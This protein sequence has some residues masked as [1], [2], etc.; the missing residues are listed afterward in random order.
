MVTVLPN[1]YHNQESRLSEW[2]SRLNRRPEYD[3]ILY[4]GKKPVCR[5]YHPGNEVSINLTRHNIAR[6]EYWKSFLYPNNVNELDLSY[7]RIDNVEDS[8]F[9]YMIN[10]RF[11][12][13]SHNYLT[14][15][16]AITSVSAL[17]TLNI[18]HNFI[19]HV[20]INR[21]HGLKLL[22]LSGNR[23]NEIG[24]EFSDLRDLEYLDLSSNLI[25]VAAFDAFQYCSSLRHLDL[26]RNLLQVFF[27]NWNPSMT[28]YTNRTRL[29][30]IFPSPTPS[31]P[32]P[33]RHLNLSHNRIKRI[34]MR[35][36]PSLQI[37]DLSFNQ[38]NGDYPSHSFY[39]SLNHSLN[40]SLN[41]SLSRYISHSMIMLDNA[42][43]LSHLNLDHNQCGER[44]AAFY[45]SIAQTARLSDLSLNY[46][47]IPFFHTYYYFSRHRRNT[48]IQYGAETLRLK[49]NEIRRISYAFGI[50]YH[51]SHIDLSHNQISYISRLAFQEM[52]MLETVDLRYN[53][54]QALNGELAA[55]TR[56]IR[57]RRKN[58]F[59]F[60]GNDLSCDC[61]STF[62][63]DIQDVVAD[64]DNITCSVV[65]GSTALLRSL[66]K[67]EFVCQYENECDEDSCSCC[68]DLSA[69]CSCR[70]NCPQ[71][72][73]CIHDVSDTFNSVKCQGNKSQNMPNA[74]HPSLKIL[75]VTGRNITQLRRQHLIN[76]RLLEKISL[77]N[78]SIQ[79]IE[80]F[81][82]VDLKHLRHLDLSF[83]EISNLEPAIFKGLSVLQ[84]L[85]LN[86][87]LLSHVAGGTF[88]ELIALKSLHLENNMLHSLNL[89]LILGHYARPD[90]YLSDNPWECS[91]LVGAMFKN[92]LS[93]TTY[94]IKDID[95][96]FCENIDV[97]LKAGQNVTSLAKVHV[98]DVDYEPCHALALNAF[99]YQLGIELGIGSGLAIVCVVVVVSLIMHYRKLLQV[100]IY[101]KCG[102][103]LNVVK[104]DSS[105]K[106][107]D[108][109]VSFSQKDGDFVFQELM[110][111]LES[112]EGFYRLC[113]HHRDWL[114]GESISNSIIESVEDSHRTILILSD[115]FMK[116]EWCNYEF[117][118]A[119]HRVLKDKN[120]HLIIVLLQDEPPEDLDKDMQRY[121]STYTYLKR[122]DPWFWE[123]LLFAMPKLDAE[124]IEWR[125][126]N[127]TQVEMM[128]ESQRQAMSARN[129]TFRDGWVVSM[130]E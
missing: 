96:I 64:Y 124:E 101:A 34:D 86:T 119:H 78:N 21:A 14:S 11:M 39:H 27:Y 103:R 102:W 125:K 116:S 32:T 87:N 77:K 7:N 13:I 100:L 122:N 37:L 130:S 73:S 42:P 93:R 109:F 25:S 45:H 8:D 117:Q 128:L 15:M 114:V 48:K 26:S 71:Q 123:K 44:C 105:R 57:E 4:P 29:E 118:A 19:S 108:A 76:S 107:Y 28:L 82:F 66:R 88:A 23:L 115:N 65:N 43:S 36:L 41:H 104:T 40:Y 5:Y 52:G 98:L 10:L 99:K 38:L 81:A 12:D 84:F 17:Q 47:G 22:D 62:M 24:T 51:V 69:E 56:Y 75:D 90:I 54:L 85:Y 50:F 61:E 53:R 112:Q 70:Y 67:E 35:S 46:N 49:G 9:I 16:T 59:Y 106:T 68:K 79:T 1:F 2:C 80:A 18:S 6:L 129:Y 63:K 89:Q 60:A 55:P 92:Q 120:C 126:S 111:K 72:C 20:D 74:Y 3:S 113:V 94:S 58:V 30:V 110:P 127:P 31:S 95:S 91:C 121:I 97:I 83:N 33:L